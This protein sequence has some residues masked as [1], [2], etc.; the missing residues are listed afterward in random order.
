M[1]AFVMATLGIDAESVL[2]VK[3]NLKKVWRIGFS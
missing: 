1:I 3:A 2:N